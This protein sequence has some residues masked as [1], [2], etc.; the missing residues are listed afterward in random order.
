MKSALIIDVDKGAGLATAKALGQLGYK[1][2]IGE[3]SQE[4]GLAAK[5]ELV[6]EGY[7]AEYLPLDLAD[8][9]T[10]LAAAETIAASSPCLDILVN[11]AGDHSFHAGTAGGLRQ[12]A[13]VDGFGAAAVTRAMLPLLRRSPVGRVVNVSSPLGTFGLEASEAFPWGPLL[14]LC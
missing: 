3:R 8:G 2:W 12:A 14:A 7:E 1:I 9:D 5:A 10:I 4:R 11:N 13:V 6:W